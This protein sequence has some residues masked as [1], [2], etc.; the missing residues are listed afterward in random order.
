MNILLINHYA[1]SPEL[2][3]EYRPYYLACQWQK[4]G[5]NV[6]ILA[7]DHSHLRLHNPLVEGDHA[8]QMI[9]GIRYCFFTTPRYVHN[10]SGR[11]KNV[12]TFLLKLLRQG[13]E[14]AERYKPDVV[15]ASS[16]YPFDIYPAR[17][18]AK[19][20]GAALVLE[21]HDLWPLTQIELYNYKESDFMVRA[22]TYAQRA[23]L[24]AAD[25]VVSILPH[26]DRYLKEFGLRPETYVHIPN[27]VVIGQPTAPPP[28][29][30]REFIDQKR[31]KGRFILLYCGSVG[32]SNGLDQL[33]SAASKLQGKVQIVL[34][35]NGS[36]KI[37]L[38]RT[39]REKGIQNVTFFD[40]IP[41]AQVQGMLALADGLFVGARPSPLYTYGIGM[42]K[43]YDYLL[44]GK[45]VVAALQ[46]EDDPITLSGGG[47][48]TPPGDPSALAAAIK[49]LAGMDEAQRS[50]M[51]QKGIDYVKAH[52]DYSNL[53]AQFLQVLEETVAQHAAQVA[54]TQEKE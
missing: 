20:A 53:G 29:R 38:K 35:G 27:G 41:K 22:I 1:G 6:T 34:V 39:V 28:P 3:M 32:L 42:N 31:A 2:G 19:L 51:G 30:Y 11:G 17:R 33:M 52:H 8:E 46:A 12:M 14:L 7:A 26:A 5:H 18:I 44:S 37:N 47:I 24:K 43:L 13:R 23:A 40:A 4:A 16:T 50:T 45:P 21:I 36:Y 25:R 9:D 15:I 10:V 49:Q 48:V 54:Q